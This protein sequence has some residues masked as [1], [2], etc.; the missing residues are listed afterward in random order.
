MSRRANGEGT[1]Y[2]RKDGR[3]EGSA[4]LGTVSGKTRR[5]HV[6]GKT[7]KEANEKL[8]VKMAEVQRGIPIPDRSWTIGDYLD[9]WMTEVAPS[10][11]RPRTMELY[12][13][14]I[15]LYL[16]S[17]VGTIALDRLSVPALQQLLNQQLAEGKTIRTVRLMRTVLSA[18]L[19]RAMRE[20]LVSRNVAR[21]VELRESERQEIVPW[22]AE[23][24]ARFLRHAASHPLYPAFLMLSLYGLRRG[25]VLGIRW[26][27]IDWD[28]DAIHI[29]QQLQQIRGHLEL[30]PVKTKAGRRTLPLLAV[31]RMAL[32][33]YHAKRVLVDGQTPST[34]LKRQALTGSQDTAVPLTGEESADIIFVGQNGLPLW[35]RN[36]VR[37]FHTLC[38]KAEVRRIKLHH[39]RHGAATLL[40]NLAVP[41]RDAQIIMG[42]AHIST[43][44][45]IYQHG[46]A[47]IQKAALDRIS[48]VLLDDA[49]GYVSRQTLPSMSEIVVHNASV[50]S[51]GPGGARTLDTLLKRRSRLTVSP[52]TTPV[53]QHLRARLS[54]RFLGGLA[55]NLAVKNT[56]SQCT[57]SRRPIMQPWLGVNP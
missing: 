12:E 51:G 9:Y 7:R 6:Y 13:S 11:L 31:V 56:L 54:I 30:G 46:D 38:E 17:L 5:L 8:T 57:N 19:T 22:T 1:I 32:N 53:I 43:T 28:H 36:F 48:Q 41:E 40:K 23:E 16:K 21:L 44:Q 14:T 45:Q 4:Y 34:I 39:L 25:E 18:A 47:Q 42:H 10:K 55:V 2:R 20:E 49:D 24:A 3:W 50:Q 33:N 26:S 29:R 15:R 35:P 27:D 37:L 52:G